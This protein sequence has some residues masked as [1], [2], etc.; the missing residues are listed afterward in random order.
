MFT[1]WIIKQMGQGYFS[2]EIRKSENGRKTMRVESSTISTLHNHSRQMTQSRWNLNSNGQ[3]AA[4]AFAFALMLA[5]ASSLS[6]PATLYACHDGGPIGF[7]SKK[8]GSFTVDTVSTATFAIAS[9][10]GTSGCR[11]WDLV[12]LLE[13]EQSRFVLTNWSGIQED[14]ARGSGPHLKALAGLIGC[15]AE[16]L[17]QLSNIA[18]N[19]DAHAKSSEANTFVKTLKRNL[20]PKT[21]RALNCEF[22][23]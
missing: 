23:S 7:A 20:N 5:I 4:F 13:K 18:R 19:V 6:N 11:N 8:P 3:A 1:T 14:A 2:E 21:G 10:S 16:A 9:T 12:Q 22:T 15:G 17:P